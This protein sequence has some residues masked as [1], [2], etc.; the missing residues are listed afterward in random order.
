MAAGVLFSS[1][2]VPPTPIFVLLV[3]LRMQTL[4]QIQIQ[5]TDSAAAA[6][7]LV[8]RARRWW[9]T[10]TSQVKLLWNILQRFVANGELCVNCVHLVAKIVRAHDIFVLLLC[11]LSLL[12]HG[13]VNY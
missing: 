1:N 13:R 12:E 3:R 11:Y 9:S 2:F 5:N 8:L 6:D 10:Q 4:H 7:F